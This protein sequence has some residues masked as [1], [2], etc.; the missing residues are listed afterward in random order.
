MPTCHTLKTFKITVRW[1]RFTS[2]L[3]DYGDS[4]WEKFVGIQLTWVDRVVYEEIFNFVLK[5]QE[6]LFDTPAD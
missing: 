5:K 4:K 6:G 1:K 3:D 2:S